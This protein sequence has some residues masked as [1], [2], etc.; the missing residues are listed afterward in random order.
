MRIEYRKR[1]SEVPVEEVVMT[2]GLINWSYQDDSDSMMKKL[3]FSSS[4]IS[5][6]VG[7]YFSSLFSRGMIE[8]SIKNLGIDSEEFEA[9]VSTFRNF[10]DFFIRRLKPACRPFSSDPTIF[11]SPGDGRLTIYPATKGQSIPVKGCKFSIKELL[12]GSTNFEESDICVLRLCPADYH[13]FHFP[14]DGE[15]TKTVDLGGMYHSVNPVALDTGI[16]VFCLNKRT[17]TFI[18]TENFGQV[19]FVE[20]GAFAVGSI[21]QTYESKTIKK[22]DEKGYF[23]FGGSTIILV[24]EKGKLKYDE[25]LIENSKNGYETLVKVGEQIAV[26]G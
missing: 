10:N 18:D 15:I 22:M 25:E 7:F 5:K 1:G 16:N 6:C 26:K 9:D 13:R 4:F 11:A 21:I 2:G 8:K 23:K 20:V 24:T 17:L 3:V 19:A 12:A 14:C